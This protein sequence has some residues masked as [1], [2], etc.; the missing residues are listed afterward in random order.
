MF[1][2]DKLIAVLTKHVVFTLL[3]LVI[4]LVLHKRLTAIVAE[5]PVVIELL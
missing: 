2:N 5:E 3:T 4:E 1:V